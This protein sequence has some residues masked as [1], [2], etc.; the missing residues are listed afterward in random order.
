MLPLNLSLTQLIIAETILV[1]IKLYYNITRAFT[2]YA[3]RVYRTSNLI[4]M[5]G[6]FSLFVCNAK[7][8]IYILNLQTLFYIWS[9]SSFVNLFQKLICFCK[10]FTTTFNN[11]FCWLFSQIHSSPIKKNYCHD[12]HLSK[13]KTTDK[14]TWTAYFWQEIFILLT[15][16]LIQYD[17]KYA[18]RLKTLSLNV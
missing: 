10:I 18:W 17:L 16:L 12:K 14:E 7:T 6:S 3:S 2:S 8:W 5:W 4:L 13:N 9:L 1:H 15:Q 11:L